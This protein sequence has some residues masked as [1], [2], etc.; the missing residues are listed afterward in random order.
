MH[1]L[2]GGL[3][4]PPAWETASPD[5]ISKGSQTQG[6]QCRRFKE[7]LP[8]SDKRSGHSG[9]SVTAPPFGAAWGWLGKTATT[10]LKAWWG[11]TA[12]QANTQKQQPPKKARC[13]AETDGCR[14]RPRRAHLLRRAG[15]VPGAQG[16]ACLCTC[17]GVRARVLGARVL[18]PCVRFGCGARACG[19]RVHGRGGGGRATWPR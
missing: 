14:R 16:L 11:Q 17:V 9:A 12:E 1:L 4:A 15:P 2:R 19:P 3:G 8:G 7:G 10:E 18:G 5:C 6:L 13:G